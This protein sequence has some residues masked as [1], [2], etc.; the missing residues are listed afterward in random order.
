METTEKLSGLR[1]E[2]ADIEAFLKTLPERQAVGQPAARPI[3]D[4]T[5]P[6]VLRSATVSPRSETDDFINKKILAFS[7]FGTQYPGGTWQDLLVTVVADLY[8]RH[9]A[10]LARCLS[11]RGPKMPYFSTSPGELKYP[12]RIADSAYYAETKLN[13]NSIVK[14]CQDLMVVFGHD[15][16]DLQIAAK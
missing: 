4:V 9:S 14:R 11:L 1:P 8:R 5:R 13:S 15:K 12:K 6:N 7:L 2:V 10:E 3:A 16:N